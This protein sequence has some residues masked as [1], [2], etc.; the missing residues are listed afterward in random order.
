MSIPKDERPEERSRGRR[1]DLAP[2]TNEPDAFAR[3]DGIEKLQLKIGGMSCSFCVATITTAL[4]RTAGVKDA[5]VN[6]AHEKTLVHYDP[7]L[8]TPRQLKETLVGLGYTVRDASHERT[9]E[10]DDAELRR[11]RNNLLLAAG[12]AATA[13]G[14]IALMWA[15]FLAPWPVR[16][17]CG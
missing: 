12:F 5:S 13:V 11:E 15:G 6:L 7:D 1:R 16:F 9:F 2:R 3:P 17:C 4:E 10:E 8:V 14:L